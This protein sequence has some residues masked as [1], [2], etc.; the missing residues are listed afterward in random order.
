MFN[1]TYFSKNCSVSCLLCHNKWNQKDEEKLRVLTVVLLCRH[2]QRD[3]YWK[4]NCFWRSKQHQRWAS[5]HMA[6]TLDTSWWNSTLNISKNN[7]NHAIISLKQIRNFCNSNNSLQLFLDFLH[8]IETG[9]N[10]YWLWIFVSVIYVTYANE[11][12]KFYADRPSF[13]KSPAN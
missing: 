9:Q 13:K 12:I 2:G 1:F 10:R 4:E 3:G 7:I 11:K 6:Q 5:Q 8:Q